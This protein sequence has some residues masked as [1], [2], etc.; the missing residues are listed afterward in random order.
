MSIYDSC[1]SAPDIYTAQDPCPAGTTAY[2][3]RAGDTL[4]AI[5]QRLGITVA[6][7]VAVNPGINP[8]NLQV[9]QQI[10]IPGAAPEFCPG[11]TPYVI[12]PG[13]TFYA[14]ASRLGISLQALL[15]ANPGV[16]P[17]RLTVGQTICIPGVPI[18][19]PPVPV[20]TPCCTVLQPVF[21]V[22][23]PGAEI[24][25]GM[26]GVSAV[27]MSTRWYTFAAVRLPAPADF[28]SFDSYVGILN[29]FV[30]GDPQQPATRVIRLVSSN[31]GNQQV[32]WSGTQVTADMPIPGE[33]AEIRPYNSVTGVQGPAFLRNDL[34]T[35]RR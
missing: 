5:A 34:G 13:D 29:V 3:V 22:L 30:Q 28:G 15:A 24:P 17:N 2:T 16:D 9:G 18:P 10:C 8:N 23:P 1:Y 33:Y 19:P 32:T 31:F 6:G 11:G 26:I 25:F 12:R 35:C 27:S 7:I 21:T 4:Y 14:I 20:G